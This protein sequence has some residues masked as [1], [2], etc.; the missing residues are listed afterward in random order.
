MLDVKVTESVDRF[1]L[2]PEHVIVGI[3][4]TITLSWKP[5]GGWFEVV[6]PYHPG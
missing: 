3:V 1:V 4:G 6:S 5:S 2:E